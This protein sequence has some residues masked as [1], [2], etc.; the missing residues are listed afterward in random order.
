MPDSI[1]VLDLFAG[2]GGLTRG[3]HEASPRFRSVAAVEFDAAAAAAFSRNFSEAA[4]HPMDIRAWL[5]EGGATVGMAKVIVGGPP[6]QGFSTLGKRKVDDERNELWRQY[7][8]TIL[9]VQPEYFVVE[10][11]AAFEK[12]PQFEQFQAST[13]GGELKD[14]AFK[15]GILN[16]ADFGAPQARKRAIL[17]GHH[18]DLPFP[19]W[20]TPTH[21]GR[22]VTVS[23]ALASIPEPTDGIDLPDHR[24][25][26]FAGRTFRGSFTA[27]ELHLSRNYTDLS[28]RRFAA[29]PPGG[30]RF[31]LP[32]DLKA[33]CWIGHTSG[34]GDVMGRLHL[35]RPSVTI[36]TEFFKPEKGRY[37]H[38][39]ANRAITHRE[40]AR[41]QGFPD[42]HRFVGSKTEMA[43]QIG[44][45]VP[46]QLGAAIAR[47]LEVA[48]R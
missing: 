37:L 44:N 36:R 39:R 34:S 22:H 16:A 43:R 4:V 21:K 30:N 19:G 25:I 40:A 23:E 3:F 35:H 42:S 11:V 24:T 46:V 41:L 17:I 31:D 27:S 26:D 29:I 14:Y 9:A 1:H 7:E 8:R 13:D 48:L 38:P 28:R 6:C 20:P 33:K 2:A 5:D 32:D 47:N 18:R 45:A 15:S 12:S 10:N